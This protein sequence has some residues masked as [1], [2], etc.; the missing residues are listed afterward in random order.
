MPTLL[1]IPVGP[2]L[3]VVLLLVVLLFG[4]EKIPEVARATGESLGEFKKGVQ[5]SDN[6]L[7]TPSSN[8]DN[9]TQNQTEN[10]TAFEFDTGTTSS[11]TELQAL[12][13]VTEEHE[14]A[15]TN[16]GITSVEELANT[17]PEKIIT[18]TNI[19]EQTTEKILTETEDLPHT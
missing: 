8:N 17:T 14:E 15:L 5:E 4:G 7:E 6:P 10:E 13:T 3:L 2:E 18:E 12:D 11:N 19:D 9:T 1:F 16:I